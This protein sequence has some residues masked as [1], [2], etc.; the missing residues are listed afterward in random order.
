MFFTKKRE[1]T[2]KKQRNGPTRAAPL[3]RGLVCLVF[4]LGL[5]SMQQETRANGMGTCM[6]ER[7]NEERGWM[8]GGEC[9]CRLDKNLQLAVNQAKTAK[10]ARAAG[11]W[12][13]KVEELKERAATLH[14]TT[15]RRWDTWTQA[16]SDERE[17]TAWDLILYW[18]GH[19]P[20]KRRTRLEK[21][22]EDAARPYIQG[23]EALIVELK[24]VVELAAHQAE[25]REL[26]SQEQ[27][28]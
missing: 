18:V 11:I 17:P 13:A 21:K 3:T 1:R 8:Y 19:G 15:N 22:Y 6:A 2:T 26:R 4:T 14:E 16:E 12:L 7:E 27:P 9:S 25:H 24:R 23:C 20:S 28:E 10:P 5:L